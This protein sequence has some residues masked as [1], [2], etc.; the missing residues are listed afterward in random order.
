VKDRLGAPVTSKVSEERSKSQTSGVKRSSYDPEDREGKR[1]KVDEVPRKK[2]KTKKRKH[3][4]SDG[5]YQ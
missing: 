3:K 4:S 2:E 5:E 1:L